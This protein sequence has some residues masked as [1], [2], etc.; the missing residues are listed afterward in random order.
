MKTCVRG[1]KV[2]KPF[3]N[4]LHINRHRCRTSRSKI[5]FKK[6]RFIDI[7]PKPMRFDSDVL[8]NIFQHIVS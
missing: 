1:C 4:F 5:K 8:D 2:L 3:R 6:C 7:R